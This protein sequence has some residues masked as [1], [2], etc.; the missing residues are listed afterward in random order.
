MEPLSLVQAEP[1]ADFD[2]F[3]LLYPRKVARKAAR[4]AWQRLS[5]DDCVAAIVGL[6]GWRR[7]WIAKGELEYVPHPASWLNGERW[8][9][10]LPSDIKATAASHLPFAATP[11]EPFKRDKLPQVALDA[12]AKLKAHR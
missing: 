6:V 5:P 10:E 12:I 4:V 1:Q 11:A 2:T 3:W 7:V 9:D 8:T